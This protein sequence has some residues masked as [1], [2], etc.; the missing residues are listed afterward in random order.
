[1]ILRAMK[2]SVL[3]LSACASLVWAAVAGAQ[4]PPSPAESS[5][6]GNT[7]TLSLVGAGREDAVIA[8]RSFAVHGVVV[9]F[10]D[11]Q[12]ATVTLTRRGE[13]VHQAT[14]PIVAVGD[15]SGA[16][17]VPYR[18][19]RAGRIS[20]AAVTTATPAHPSLTEEGLELT[21][22]GRRPGSRGATVRELQR[23]L[24]RKGYVVG[25]P[26]VYDGRTAR[27]VMAFRKVTG[28]RR[29]FSAGPE[30]IRALVRG[31]GRYRI[32][33]PKHGR[34]IEA[35]LSRQVMV[36]AD[37]ARALRIYHVS[38]GAPATP[39]V[40]GRFRVY[41]RD[42]G[43][44]AKGMVDSSYFIGG[45]AIHGYAQVPAFNASHGCLRVPVPDARSI[46]SWIRMRTRVDVYR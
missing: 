18:T 1:M 38:S 5:P 44:N 6:T 29:S 37:G 41:R 21:V 23:L 32:R 25:R 31:R 35:D 33:Y 39:T 14:V 16:F 3:L 11:G 19:R 24:R 42:P 28:M 12:Q 36:L 46:F 20:I 4:A 34:H 8:G 15:G 10:Q 17:D 9:P 43:T 26:G 22:I 30:V 7:L 40:V 45:Y 13:V 2:R 27:A